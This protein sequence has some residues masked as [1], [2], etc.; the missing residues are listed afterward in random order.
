MIIK[1]SNGVRKA[2]RVTG[3][4]LKVEVNAKVN[5]SAK[6]EAAIKLGWGNCW[7]IVAACGLAVGQAAVLY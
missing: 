6:A 4:G 2:A 3:D 7:K 5:V 1:K